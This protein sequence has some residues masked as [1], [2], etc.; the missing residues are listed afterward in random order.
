LGDG[1]FGP[2]EN[3]ESDLYSNNSSEGAMKNEHPGVSP[4]LPMNPKEQIFQKIYHRS[5]ANIEDSVFSS[6][7][8]AL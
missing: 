7:L 8:Q 5:L 6:W 3:M 1:E 4:T 2:E